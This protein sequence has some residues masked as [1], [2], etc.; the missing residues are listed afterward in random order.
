MTLSIL[1]AFIIGLVLL[2]SS[3]YSFKNSINNITLT[4]SLMTVGM[5]IYSLGYTWELA[6]NTLNSAIMSIK[7]QYLGLSFLSVYW[8][9]IVYRFRYDK[10]IEH[11]KVVYLCLIPVLTFFLV[12]TNEMHHLYYKSVEL[13]SY[14]NHFVVELHKGLFYYVFVLN[15]YVVLVFS[16]YSLMK[17]WNNS[18]NNLKLQNKLLLM[19]ALIA[20]SCNIVYLLKLMPNNYD[21]TPI[22]FGVM[23]YFWFLGIFK[24]NYLDLKEQ[25]RIASFD[26]I[27]ETIFVIDK[28]YKIIDFNNAASLVFEFMD[29]VNIGNRID[30]YD[31]GKIIIENL[32][33]DS[34]ELVLNIENKNRQYEFR[35]TELFINE[36]LLA[37][38]YVC[39]DVTST[40]SMI[41][42]LSYLATHDFLTG[43]YNRMNFLNLA[44]IELDRARRYQGEF[45]L[46]ML[47]I[48]HFKHVNDTYGHMAG[49]EVIKGLTSSIE[50]RLRTTD[51]FGRLG[52]EEFLIL[53]PETSL[54]GASIF[55]EKLRKSVELFPFHLAEQTIHITISL[56][57][58]YYS[59]NM[60]DITIGDIMELA[61]RAVY[62]SK[63]SGRNKVSCL[64]PILYSK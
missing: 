38:V 51:V 53:L 57:I 1:V 8:I 41:T 60:E 29:R 10:Y 9:A 16:I 37:Y 6:S 27:R 13:V 26:K 46:V 34:F 4:F 21:L 61:D 22:G 24:Y 44:E 31:F 23:S 12:M 35:K 42:N 5:A 2:I 3:F 30:N 63:N 58:S 39:S 62:E 17:T 59:Y 43:I 28:E 18:K 7:F 49:D 64:H 20:A 33:K 50:T 54:D 45:A 40:N 56:G 32:H 19:G 47:D 48:D 25:V 15:S 36:N 14:K 11:H 52:G 55:A